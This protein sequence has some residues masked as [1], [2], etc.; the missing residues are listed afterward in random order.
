MIAEVIFFDVFSKGSGALENLV[1]CKS[2]GSG[3][4]SHVD[5]DN[6]AVQALSDKEMVIMLRFMFF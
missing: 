1:S 4:S 3:C 2:G 5:E 6:D